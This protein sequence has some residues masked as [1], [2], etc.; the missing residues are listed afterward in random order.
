[1]LTKGD[2]KKACDIVRA[3][4]HAW[5]PYSLLASGCPA[6]EFE[7]E[8]ASVVAQIP[9]INSETDAASAS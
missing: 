3:V 4:I 2:Y 7:S 5:D 1:M 8:I 6:D 9:R